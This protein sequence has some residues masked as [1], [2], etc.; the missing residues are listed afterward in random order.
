MELPPQ[1]A[2]VYDLVKDVAPLGSPDEEQRMRSAHAWV[3]LGL[4][5]RTAST[6]TESAARHAWTLN[7]GG[8]VKAFKA[9]WEGENGP[10]RQLAAGSEGALLTGLGTMAIV[11]LRV[12]W[13]AYVIYAL[14]ILA[15]SLLAALAAGP[16]SAFI[17][18]ARVAGVRHALMQMRKKFGEHVQSVIRDTL[19]RAKGLALTLIPLYAMPI[20]WP[21]LQLYAGAGLLRPDKEAQRRTEEVLR[22]TPAGREALAWA[23]DHSITVVYRPGGINGNA[24]VGGYADELDLLLIDTRDRTPEQLAETFVHEVNHARNEGKPNP[25]G[26][27]RE[28]YIEAALNE[29]V[30]G[31]VKAYEMTR[32]LEAARG[33]DVSPPPDREEIREQFRYAYEKQFDKEWGKRY[34][35]AGQDFLIPGS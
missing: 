1:L 8:D 9:H 13:K 23:K 5:L 14:A 28:E 30:D 24:A 20:A 6:E 35:V 7:E 16:A 3:D 17:Q 31:Y 19:R 15:A 25:I 11:L 27:G 12:M 29:E 26:M 10:G 32:Q 33:E 2:G 34:F 21:A 4:G 22:E 18:H